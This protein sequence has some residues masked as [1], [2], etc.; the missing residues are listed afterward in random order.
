MAWST[1]RIWRSC[2]GSGR[3][4]EVSIR[5]DLA[6]ES[7]VGRRSGGLRTNPHPRSRRK[8]TVPDGNRPPSRHTWSHDE[9]P[10]PRV[11][12]LRV[13]C[14]RV[15]MP[16]RQRRTDDGQGQHADRGRELRPQCGGRVLLLQRPRRQQ[17]WADPAARTDRL[18]SRGHS[19]GQHHHLRVAH[20]SLQQ[21]AIGKPCAADQ[22]ASNAR[23]LGRGHVGRLRRRRRA[24]DAG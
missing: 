17:R 5:P 12:C 21:G 3:G 11:R 2:S 8:R 16:C 18:R 22:V 20:P 6:L 15:R 19:R 10:P 24:G 1:G 13:S 9:P 7:M 4:R 14:R 23:G